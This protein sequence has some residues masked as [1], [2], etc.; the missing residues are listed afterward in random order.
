MVTKNVQLN[1]LSDITT[2]YQYGAS[3]HEYNATIS[4]SYGNTG[5]SEIHDT[6]EMKKR[7]AYSAYS[8]QEV[9]NLVKVDDLLPKNV[10][11]NF[12]L[13]DVEKME[14]PALTGMKEVIARSPNLVLMVEWQRKL[15]SDHKTQQLLDFLYEKGYSVYINTR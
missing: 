15:Q 11:L 8:E 9:V 13:I 14:V 12:A 7:N 10:S 1:G 6:E 4:V 5:G 3:D 2:V